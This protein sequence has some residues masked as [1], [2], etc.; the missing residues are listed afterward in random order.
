VVLGDGLSVGCVHVGQRGSQ[1]GVPSLGPSSAVTSLS[2]RS[3][4]GVTT[5]YLWSPGFMDLCN[6]KVLTHSNSLS[7]SLFQNCTVHVDQ[8]LSLFLLLGALECVFFIPG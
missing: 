8:C 2:L 6:K 4:G 1:L 5:L 7:F 3:L